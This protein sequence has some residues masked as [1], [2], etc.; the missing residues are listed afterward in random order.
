MKRFLLL[1]SLVI[2]ALGTLSSCNKKVGATDR[3]VVVL[4]L[5][6]FRSDYASRGNTPTLDSLAKVGVYAGFRPEFPS[7]TFPNHYAMATGL[8]PDHHGLIN[9]SFYAPDLDKI[10][11]IGNRV[12]VE[13]PDFY[14]GEPIWNTAERQGVRAATFFWVGSET[15]VGG[16]QASIW[17]KYDG[18][19]PYLD[20]V[21]SVISWLSLPPEKRPHL[22]MWYIE[23]PDAV[24]HDETP[25]SEVVIDKVE[26]LDK[27]LA[28]FFNKARKLDIYKK[29][30]FIIVSDHGMAT[31][32]PENYVNLYKYLPRDS[33]DYVFD[34]T[35]TYLYPKPTFT[36]TAYTILKEVPNITVYKKEEMPEEFVYGTNDRIGDLIVV[37]D[38]GTYVQFRENG[39][40]YL[41]GAHGYNNFEKEME[42][43]FYAAGPR[44]NKGMVAPTMANLNLYLVI[45]NILGIEPAQNDCDTATVNNLFRKKYKMEIPE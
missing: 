6:G 10:Y 2:F 43:I 18:T 12:A 15:A 3:Y 13:N 16:K 39:T 36:E 42:G 33:F 31:Y 7:N 40:G 38:I 32:K 27:V 26:E 30:D 44:F 24:A 19:V 45:S 28:Y 20:R 17:K 21:D 22:V 34:G 23:E 29:I 11:T 5:D 4:S 9:N 41:G 8:H 14:G 1:T 25:D 35:P 37:P